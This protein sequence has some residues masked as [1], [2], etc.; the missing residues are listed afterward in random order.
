MSN[1]EKKLLTISCQ[2]NNPETILDIATG[3]GDLAH[4]DDKNIQLKK[5]VGLDLSAGM[6]DIGKQKIAAKKSYLIK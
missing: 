1:G 6:L 3:T 2:I 5:I 4:H